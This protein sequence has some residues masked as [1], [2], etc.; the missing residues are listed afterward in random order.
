M[1]K[2]KTRKSPRPSPLARHYYNGDFCEYPVDMVLSAVNDADFPYNSI[3]IP[4]QLKLRQ[5]FYANFESYVY[6]VNNYSDA[7][8]VEFMAHPNEYM[9]AH[10][11]NRPAPIDTMT[12]EI[13]AMCADPALIKAIRSDSLSNVNS[14]IERACWKKKYPKRYPKEFFDYNVIWN[15]AGVEAFPDV[16]FEAHGFSKYFDVYLQYVT[17]T[18]HL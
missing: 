3:A 9:Q 16:D 15:V 8:I 12:A 1:I 2:E 17:R 13:M 11:V 18:L 10:N 6:L 4:I 14:V 7:A 5:S